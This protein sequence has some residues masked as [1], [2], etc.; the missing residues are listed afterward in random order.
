MK[1]ILITLTIILSIFSSR[2]QQS[3]T[4]YNMEGVNQA[5]QVNPSMIPGNK[6][7]IGIP[8]L[9][10]TNFLFTNS[11]FTW[12]DLQKVRADDSI[13]LDIENAI[14]KL[15]SKNFISLSFRMN[16]VETGFKVK[17]NYFTFNVAEKLNF[18]LTFPKE[19]FEL[20][21]RG[22]GA[23]VGQEVDLKRMSFDLTHYR[24]YAIGWARDLS[25]KV[26][27]GT[28]IKYL[29]GMENVS[30]AK[31]NLNFYTNPDDYALELNSDYIIN[32][33]MASNSEGSSGSYLFGFK[34]TGWATDL[35]T[36]YK[37]NDR[38]K[39][40]ASII[41][42][43]F[44]RWKSNV[45]NFVTLNGSYHFDGVDLNDFMSN[46]GSSSSD[47]SSSFGHVTD[48]ISS[49][50]N[51]EEN[52]D[53][54]TT[55]LPTQIYLNA[56]YQLDQRMSA[57]FLIHGQYFRSTVQPTLTAGLNRRVTNHI[58]ASLNYSMINHHFNNVGVGIAA[59]AGAFQFYMISD[60]IIGTINPLSNNTAHIQFGFNLIF[61][62]PV[63]KKLTTNYGVQDKSLPVIDAGH[64]PDNTNTKE[65]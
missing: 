62:R 65:Q 36:T 21:F 61:G 17:K 4:L 48:S 64:V 11:G 51:P 16:L 30:S 63:I 54:Y 39:F 35:S 38:W 56:S 10:S 40:N 15:A 22:N 26:T 20:L 24:E 8:V 53:A 55:Y 58:Y 29:Y 33:S 46:N 23:F 57:T 3:L 44:I 25:K 59:N 32:T 28:R 49:S 50:F 31:T 19:L 13:Q 60:N 18:N 5:T 6:M 1:H 27:F 42:L 45:K 9:S 34:N 12:R 52:K 37:Y 7:Y 47:S 43:G 41:D 2:A 14:S